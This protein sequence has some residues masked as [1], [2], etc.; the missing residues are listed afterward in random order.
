MDQATDLWHWWLAL[1]RPFADGFT[2]PGWVRFV[3]WVTGM[4][5]CWEEHTITQLLTALGLESRWRVLE[6]FAEYGAWDHEAVERHTLRLIEQERPARW[7]LYHPIA[8]DDTKGHRTS[9]QVWGTCTF[10]EA[11]ARS[12]NRAETVRAHNW[13]VM[14]DLHPG[15]P[16]TYLPHAARLYWRQRQLPVGETFRT[17]T[18]LA[19]ELLRQ[20]D[21]ESPAPILA[22]F[23]GAYAVQTVVRPCVIPPPGQRPIALVTRLR[24]DAR[25]YHPVV[26]RL[27]AKGRPPQWGPRVAA[28]QHHLY[29]PASWQRSRAWAYGRLRSFQ[30]KQLRCRWA[31]SGPVVP[32]HV[33]AVTIEGYQA[34]WFL[35]TSALEL[36]AAQVVEVWAARFRQEDGFRDHKQR[37]G[38][39]ECR[40]WTKAPILRTFQVQLVALTLLRLL[41][42]HVD[43]AWGAGCWWLKPAWNRRKCHASLLD[44]RRLF[45]RYRTEFSQFLMALEELEKLPQPHRLCSNSAE[46]AA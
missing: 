27:Q 5:L 30:Y 12:P 46:D 41:Q 44:L 35:V 13:V 39:E 43:R 36:S 16:W 14:G 37:L 2:R 6:H 7:G 22:V 17:K 38:M 28:P 33:F 20:A 19:V 40:A 26:P 31:V 10:H 11:S 23:D 15:R 3:Q 42:M 24:A 21:R 45:W 29:W 1:L 34:P 18:A 4:V 25:L 8:L 9:K 32:V